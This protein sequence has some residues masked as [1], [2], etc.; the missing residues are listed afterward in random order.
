M[1]VPA[2]H[3]S[4][5]WHPLVII[6]YFHSAELFHQII[7]FEFTKELYFEE[8]FKLACNRG[9][10]DSSGVLKKRLIMLFNMKK[11]VISIHDRMYECYWISNQSIF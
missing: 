11:E 7:L 6:P 5:H 1:I 8:Y 2:R 10:G 9:I 4:A 3:V